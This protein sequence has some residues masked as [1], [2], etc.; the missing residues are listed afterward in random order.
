MRW[1]PQAMHRAM[2]WKTRAALYVG[3]CIAHFMG[4]IAILSVQTACTELPCADSWTFDGV[5]GLWLFPVF[6]TPLADFP[7]QDVEMV[8]SWRLFGM[9]WLNAALA[10]AF[11]PL[12]WLAGKRGRA[13][14]LAR[15]GRKRPGSVDAELL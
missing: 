9:L 15:R 11:Y 10:C 8:R 2:V 7:A 5:R 4:S 13:V 6:H 12:M 14:W 3:A 1:D